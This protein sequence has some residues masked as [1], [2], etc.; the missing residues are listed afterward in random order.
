ME[1][2]RAYA[3]FRLD[4]LDARGLSATATLRATSRADLPQRR[5]HD[6]IHS[7]TR[8]ADHYRCSHDTRATCLTTTP[9]PRSPWSRRP[10]FV[11]P[12]HLPVA[13]IGDSTDG[14]RLAEYAGR[15]CT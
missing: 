2:D 1:R 6:Q 15:L 4:L 5:D 13:W 10:S 11:E 3:T 7:L 8:P 9:S 12:E 14:E